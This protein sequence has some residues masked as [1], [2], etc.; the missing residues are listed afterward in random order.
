MARPFENAADW[1]RAQAQQAA[2]VRGE[3]LTA[4]AERAL[5]D[6]RA[7][8]TQVEDILAA[9]VKGSSLPDN[10]PAAVSRMIAAMERAT[11]LMS[12]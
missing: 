5:T 11:R 4:E 2:K 3:P 6:F 8:A 7:A 1:L 12:S 9:W 10:L